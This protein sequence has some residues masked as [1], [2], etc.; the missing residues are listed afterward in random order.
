M[1][2]RGSRARSDASD[3]RSNGLASSLR[4]SLS[5]AH[6]TSVR[7]HR[8]DER[9]SRRRRPVRRRRPAAA[10]CSVGT[11]VGASLEAAAGE[12]RQG[13]IT[14]EGRV[15]RER[16]HS[17]NCDPRSD[18]IGR[19]WRQ[20]AHSR[21]DD[22]PCRRFRRRSGAGGEVGIQPTDTC[23]SAVFKTAAID[24]SATSPTGILRSEADLWAPQRAPRPPCRQPRCQPRDAFA[25]SNQRR[26]ERRW[27]PACGSSEARRF[28]TQGGGPSGL[29]RAT[30]LTPSPHVRLARR[31]Q[32]SSPRCPPREPDWP[33]AVE[34]RPN[35]QTD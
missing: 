35:E 14:S 16:R 19:P 2:G 31:Y 32:E 11:V 8:P 29:P 21:A 9:A 25:G 22:R 28:R 27:A 17:Q 1:D 33:G 4:S 13:R 15:G 7:G 3:L 20:A 26:R 24:H 5:S 34:E 18:W 12:H 23:V 6:L 10:S 30:E